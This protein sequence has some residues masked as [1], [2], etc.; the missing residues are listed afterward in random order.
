MTG[1]RLQ[2][3]TGFETPTVGSIVFTPRCQCCDSHSALE[4]ELLLRLYE[5]ERKL[6][7]RNF[8]KGHSFAEWLNQRRAF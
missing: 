6:E 8:A 1:K 5:T 3:K 7:E 2:P 4:Q